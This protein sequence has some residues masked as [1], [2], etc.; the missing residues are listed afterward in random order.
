MKPARTVLRRS[1]RKS[2][3]NVPKLARFLAIYAAAS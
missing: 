1:S 3:L 2:G